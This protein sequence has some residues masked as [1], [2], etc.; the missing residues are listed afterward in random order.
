MGFSA[1]TFENFN[2]LLLW[3]KILWWKVTFFVLNPYLRKDGGNFFITFSIFLRIRKYKNLWKYIYLFF[4]AK[5]DVRKNIITWCILP[6]SANI[7]GT[8]NS[9][10]MTHWMQISLIFNAPL[11]LDV[12]LKYLTVIYENKKH[13][14]IKHKVSLFLKQCSAWSWIDTTKLISAGISWRYH[15]IVAVKDHEKHF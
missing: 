9:I 12:N 11:F 13:G 3:F 4:S 14:K 15:K 1:K 5:R 10:E 2:Q 8:V 7:G 6:R